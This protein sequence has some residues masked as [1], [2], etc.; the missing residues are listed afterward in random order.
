MRFLLQNNRFD[1]K[2]TGNYVVKDY[3]RSMG[4]VLMHHYIEVE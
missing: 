4:N 3:I 2:H 1:E